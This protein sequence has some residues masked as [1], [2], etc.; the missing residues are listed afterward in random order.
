MKLW[1]TQHCAILRAG[2]WSNTKYLK[3]YFLHTV[4]Q[5]HCDH[6]LGDAIYLSYSREVLFHCSND[7]LILLTIALY[8]DLIFGGIKP[9]LMCFFKTYLVILGCVSIWNLESPCQFPQKESYV[10]LYWV[11]INSVEKF[12]EICIFEF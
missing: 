8:Q 4:V 3:D 2:I 11:S 7:N 10:S 9:L 1:R 6:E 5:C 12:A